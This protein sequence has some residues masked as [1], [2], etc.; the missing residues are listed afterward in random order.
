MAISEELEEFKAANKSLTKEIKV[1]RQEYD[2]YQK[3]V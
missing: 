2:S 1:I 3:K